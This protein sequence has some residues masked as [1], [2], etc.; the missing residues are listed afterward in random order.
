MPVKWAWSRVRELNRVRSKTDDREWMAKDSSH[1]VV[2]VSGLPPRM[3]PAEDTEKDR[4]LDGVRSQSYLKVGKRA[5]WLPTG[6]K[7]GR[8][9]RWVALYLLF[10]RNQA[11]P[12]D[13]GDKTI[14]FVTRISDQKISRKFKLKDMVLE[15]KLAF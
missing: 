10:P 15:G 5:R 2:S 1:V 8:Q 9:Q 4:F 14:E 3:I 7:L 11:R 13:P 12:V 6:A